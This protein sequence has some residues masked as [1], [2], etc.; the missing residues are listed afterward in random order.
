MR[1]DI[2]RRTRLSMA[3]VLL[4]LWARHLAE[5]LSWQTLC[6][7]RLSMTNAKRF[8]EIYIVSGA[9]LDPEAR[10]LNKGCDKYV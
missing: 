1:T 4:A 3:V 9:F 5:I 6:K 7:L 2:L 10:I 8:G